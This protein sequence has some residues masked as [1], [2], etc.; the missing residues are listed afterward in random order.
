MC[1]SVTSISRVTCVLQCDGCRGRAELGGSAADLVSRCA[2]ESDGQCV[3]VSVAIASSVKASCLLA[4]CASS[5]YEVVS[6]LWSVYLQGVYKYMEGV[7]LRHFQGTVTHV[8]A[9]GRQ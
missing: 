9:C 4:L 7:V 8:A 5:Y 2:G 1:S 6:S 3:G